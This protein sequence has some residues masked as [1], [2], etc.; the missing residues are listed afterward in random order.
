[1]LKVK[2]GEFSPDAPRQTTL[3]P[4]P[5]PLMYGFCTGLRPRKKWFRNNKNTRTKRETKKCQINTHPKNIPDETK[6]IIS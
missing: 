1:M 6:S 5:H 3:K 4:N 2:C